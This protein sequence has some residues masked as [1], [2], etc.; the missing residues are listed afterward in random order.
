M[1]ETNKNLSLIED[2][3]IQLLLGYSTSFQK[4]LLKGFWKVE[5]I[6][7]IHLKYSIDQQNTKIK[8]VYSTT[9]ILISG[10]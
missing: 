8:I 4:W 7:L 6:F 3:V 5:G 10:T 9:K 1:S 2:F